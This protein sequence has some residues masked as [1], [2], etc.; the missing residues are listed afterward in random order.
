[1]V[2]LEPTPSSPG[3]LHKEAWEA[4]DLCFSP[5]CT[6]DHLCVLAKALPCSVTQLSHLYSNKFSASFETLG[7]LR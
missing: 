5:H 7:A 4:E 1:M 3:L 6:L 2:G